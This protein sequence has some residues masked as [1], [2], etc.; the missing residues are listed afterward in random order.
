MTS[1]REEWDV[2]ISQMHQ[3]DQLPCEVEIRHRV[4]VVLEVEVERVLNDIQHKG[5]LGLNHISLV[6]V[7]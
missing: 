3:E 5:M 7:V 2:E 1:H 6:L 4:E